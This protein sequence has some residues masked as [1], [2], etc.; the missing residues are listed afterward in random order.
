MGATLRQGVVPQ[1]LEG[2]QGCRADKC[3]GWQP[4]AALRMPRLPPVACRLPDR[5]QTIAHEQAMG[6]TTV[7]NRAGPSSSLNA[8]RR[9]RPSVLIATAQSQARGRRRQHQPARRPCTVAS[10]AGETSAAKGGRPSALRLFPE[11]G[12][13]TGRDKFIQRSTKSVQEGQR[14]T[15]K[16]NYPGRFHPNEPLLL[17]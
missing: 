14:R 1:R 4:A 8:W 12:E 5:S 2:L 15:R 7:K 13:R 3:S 9:C 6:R 10:G 17:V 16:A 11:Q